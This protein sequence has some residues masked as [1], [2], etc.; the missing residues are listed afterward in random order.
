M[1]TRSS[2]ARVGSRAGL[3]LLPALWLAGCGGTVPS[4][5]G[6]GGE[7]DFARGERLLKQQR[8]LQAVEA[9]ERFRTEHPGSDRIDDAIFYLGQAHQGLGE[10]LLAR[11]EF[12]RLLRDFPQ[13]DRREDAQFER[14]V[15]WLSETHGA[16]LDPQPTEA[17]LEAFRAYLRIYPEGTHREAA[18]ASVA[19]CLDRLAVKAL[20]NGE[21]YLRLKQGKA[22]RIYFEKALA[23][24]PEFSRAGEAHLGLG[25]SAELLGEFDEARAAYR[26]LLESATPERRQG[27]K[28]LRK[29]ARE[30]ER[31]LARLGEPSAG[32]L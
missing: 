16:A 28:D 21:T 8:H 13:S 12:E 18:E 25:R 15:S 14:A 17:A 26:R 22:A 2:R 10:H 27:D 5:G 29:L 4:P 32:R 7:A 6:P 24:A 3:V 23:I 20:L 30:A 9:L 11:E 1:R 19:R 31:A